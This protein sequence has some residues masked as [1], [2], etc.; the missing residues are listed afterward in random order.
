MLV[1]HRDEVNW[2]GLLTGLPAW[3]CTD[4]ARAPRTLVLFSEALYD[5]HDRGDSG[6][7]AAA[8]LRPSSASKL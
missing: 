7:K 4:T 6:S 3:I 5:R 1:C 8:T 2:N